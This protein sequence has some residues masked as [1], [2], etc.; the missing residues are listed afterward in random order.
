MIE[1]GIFSSAGELEQCFWDADEAWE[2][3][4]D[5]GDRAYVSVVCGLCRAEEAW[6]CDCMEDEDEEDNES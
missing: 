6:T 3:L 4:P 1:Y 5:Y 2:A